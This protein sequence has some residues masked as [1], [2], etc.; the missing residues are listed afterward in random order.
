MQQTST[1]SLQQ[2]ENTL[3]IKE[4][5]LCKLRGQHEQTALDLKNKI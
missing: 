4:D 5:E 1:D 3:K 2:V